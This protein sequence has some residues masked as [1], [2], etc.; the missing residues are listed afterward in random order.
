MEYIRQATQD[1]IS[2]IAEIWVF[3]R[4]INFLPIFMDYQYAFKDQQVLTVAQKL[5][6]QPELLKNYYVYDDGIVKG[7]IHIEGEEVVELY[8]DAFFQNQSI[9]SQLLEYAVENF[10]VQYLWVLEKNIRAITF[11]ERNGFIYSP[12][13]KYEEDTTEHLIKMIREHEEWF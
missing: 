6:A 11:Y 5:I 3:V 10:Y 8:V 2:R 4:R 13:W 7:F 9:G 12:E 1:D